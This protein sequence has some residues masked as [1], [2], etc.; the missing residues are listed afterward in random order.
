VVQPGRSGH[1]RIMRVRSDKTSPDKY[2]I[3]PKYVRK[4]QNFRVLRVRRNHDDV[5][6]S[7][8]GPLQSHIVVVALTAGRGLGRGWW[9]VRCP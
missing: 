7:W 4:P 3:V 2:P 5:T 9:Y 8:S 6:S 1:G